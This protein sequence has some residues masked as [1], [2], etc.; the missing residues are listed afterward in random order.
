MG[1]DR[2]NVPPAADVHRHML[3]TAKQSPYHQYQAVLLELR[4]TE[5]TKLMR[6]SAEVRDPSTAEKLYMSAIRFAL[7]PCQT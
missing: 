2:N 3:R 7:T 5:I 4:Y 1:N 6:M